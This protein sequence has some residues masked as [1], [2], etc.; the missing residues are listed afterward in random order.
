MSVSMLT[1]DATEEGG[2]GDTLRKVPTNCEGFLGLR[3]W[4]E[5]TTSQYTQGQRL[6]VGGVFCGD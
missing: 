5:H 6:S 3:K 2:S 1:N 4:N